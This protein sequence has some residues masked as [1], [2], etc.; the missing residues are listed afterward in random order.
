MHWREEQKAEARQ[1]VARVKSYQLNAHVTDAKL[2]RQFPDLG[3]TKTWRQR[4]LADDFTGLHPDRSLA[5][6]RRVN[7]I[8]DGGLPDAEF[9]RLPFTAELLAR[10]QLLER[11]TSD[12]RIL[13]CLAPNGCGKTTTARW[14]VSQSP[15][16]RSYVRLRPGQ[17]NKELHIINHMLLS[18]SLGGE[19]TSKVSGERMLIAGLTQPRTIFLDQAHE[20]GPAVMHLLRMLVDE[21]PSRFVYLGYDTAFRRVMSAD[22]DT[23]IEAQAFLGR[24]LKPIFNAYKAG[25]S[26]S[27]VKAF[28]QA[29]AD[30][31]SSVAAGL[32]NKITTLLQRNCNLRLLADAVDAARADGETDDVDPEAVVRACVGLAGMDPKSVRLLEEE[33]P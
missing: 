1:I 19:T 5:R 21:T 15:G 28:L 4:L 26:A 7:T 11:S 31:D 32:A 17:R 10:V 20:G 3:S 27:D 16:D 18:L 14:C 30:L 24:C 12:R 6:L 22:S 8:L 23:M 2:L 9:Y 13:V 25:T 29:T 33:E